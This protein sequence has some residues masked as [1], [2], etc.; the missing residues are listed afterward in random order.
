[1]LVIGMGMICNGEITPVVNRNSATAQA[2]PY[3]E[4]KAEDL[5]LILYL[6]GNTRNQDVCT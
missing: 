4:E 5:P 6:I 3:V 1:M 2:D